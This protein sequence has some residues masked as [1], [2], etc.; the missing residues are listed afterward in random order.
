MADLTQDGERDFKKR[1]Q[2]KSLF[3][4]KDEVYSP[5]PVSGTALSSVVAGLV[6]SMDRDGGA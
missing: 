2:G 1:N 4:I 5:T 6:C 3:K